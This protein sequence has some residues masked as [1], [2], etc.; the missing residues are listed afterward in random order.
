MAH[1]RG[2]D[3][4]A[5]HSLGKASTSQWSLHREHGLLRPDRDESTRIALETVF[6]ADRNKTGTGT[7]RDDIAAGRRHCRGYTSK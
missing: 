3:A 7:V 1:R 2:V 5:P 4:G 6:D